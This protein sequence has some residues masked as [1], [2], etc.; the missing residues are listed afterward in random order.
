M[1][2]FLIT[3]AMLGWA[4]TVL[5]QGNAFPNQKGKW[6]AMWGWNRDVFSASNIHF[7]GDNYDFRLRNVVA[8]DK[9][10]K[11]GFS[12]YFHPTKLTIPQ[13]DARVGYFLNNNYSVSFGFDH[14][15]Y[16]MEQSQAVEITGHIGATETAYDGDY[17]HDVIY[18]NRNFLRYEHTDGLNYV[19]AEIRRHAPIF[20]IH[21]NKWLQIDLETFSGLGAGFMLP[22][23]NC[24]MFGGERH[25]AYHLSGYATHAV[26]GLGLTLW[27]HFYMTSELKAGFINMP[28][29]RTTSRPSDRAAQHFWFGEFAVI[30][31]GSFKIWK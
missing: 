30:V 31:G 8:H 23:T 11:L 24:R 27:N 5:A 4:C 12:P 2:T 16:V 9:P 25:D 17:D 22:K 6:Y 18:T 7:W 10:E 15:K 29:I 3:W 20:S 19:N 13:T 14:M 28:D 21:K 26:T 1:R